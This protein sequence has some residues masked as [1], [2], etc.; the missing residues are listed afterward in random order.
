MGNVLRVGGIFYLYGNG[1]TES[2]DHLFTGGGA[3]F[4]QQFAECGARQAA[5]PAEGCVPAG[6]GGNYGGYFY[7]SLRDE[8]SDAQLTICVPGLIRGELQANKTVT[9]NGFITRRVVNNASRIDIQ[10]TVRTWKYFGRGAAVGSTPVLNDTLNYKV[11]AVIRDIPRQSHFH[12]DIFLS[13]TS[14]SEKYPPNWGGGYTTCLLLRPGANPRIAGRT[15]QPAGYA[16]R[17]VLDEQ[18]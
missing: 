11:T 9:V 4:V 2:D 10:L 17:Q 7:D 15:V 16:E 13:M 5:D 12:F 18:K 8:S 1:G 14:A 3:A 6:Q